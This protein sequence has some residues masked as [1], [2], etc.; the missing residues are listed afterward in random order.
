MGAQWFRQGS[1]EKESASRLDTALIV[2]KT[3]IAN[4]NYHYE[5]ALAA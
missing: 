4:N 1:T 3:L 2:Q 5:Q